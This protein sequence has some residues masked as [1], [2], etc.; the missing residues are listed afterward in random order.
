MRNR[1]LKVLIVVMILYF[2]TILTAQSLNFLITKD[3]APLSYEEN[4]VLKGLTVDIVKEIAEKTGCN[5]SM[6]SMTFE[7]AYKKIQDEGNYAIPTL[8]FTGERKSLFQ[9]VGPLAITNTY[10][11]SRNDLNKDILT[12]EDAKKVE[13]IGVVKDYYSHQLLKSQG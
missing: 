6:S 11:Y 5:I 2:S 7:E 4:G 3:Y 8:V 13:K 1:F 9:W 12:L 10:L